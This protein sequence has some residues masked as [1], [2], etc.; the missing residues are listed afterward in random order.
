MPTL[1]LRDPKATP[2]EV[3][4][5]AGKD[6]EIPATAAKEQLLSWYY[7]DSRVNGTASIAIAQRANAAYSERLLNANAKT[8]LSITLLWSIVAVVVSLIKRID[9]S[10]FILGVALPLLPA[11]L[12]VSDQ[13]RTTRRAGADRRSMADGIEM[14]LRGRSDHELS[15]DDLLVWQEQLYELRRH[16]PQVPN[17]IYKRTRQRNERIMNTAAADLATVA[18]QRQPQRS[19]DPTGEN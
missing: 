7:F 4:A 2:E 17:L 8:W 5:L 11:L 14:A 1:A 13:W 18:I 9:L 16:S 12:D 3:A 15:G 10:T 6:A 19:S